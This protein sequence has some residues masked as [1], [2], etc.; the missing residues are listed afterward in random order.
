MPFH[1]FSVSLCSD[2]AARQLSEHYLCKP[3]PSSCTRLLTAGPTCIVSTV[4][5][6]IAVSPVVLLQVVGMSPSFVCVE[7]FLGVCVERMGAGGFFFSKSTV[8]NAIF[9]PC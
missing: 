5:E 7:F 9:P 4:A 8:S 1:Y 3:L 2:V 6:Y